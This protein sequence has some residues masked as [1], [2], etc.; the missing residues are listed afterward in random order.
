MYFTTLL[1]FFNL[2]H[3]ISSIKVA[4]NVSALR[5][6]ASSI[7][8]IA[9]LPSVAARCA[10]LLPHLRLSPTSP[11]PSLHYLATPSA[12]PSLLHSF[13][14]TS[15]D[16]PQPKPR[17]RRTQRRLPSRNCSQLQ[18]RRSRTPLNRTMR[19]LQL[20]RLPTAPVTSQ[21]RPPAVMPLG[22]S[23]CLGKVAVWIPTAASAYP[24]PNLPS[25]LETFSS[26]LPRTTFLASWVAS[27]R[28]STCACCA[29]RAG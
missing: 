23:A 10:S 12:R 22:C 17:S 4:Q 14:S 3:S 16:G 5:M 26:T 21:V 18:L 29:I 27:V 20:P 24:C 25:T 8:I 11:G 28:S 15:E 19:K 9:G 7:L 13:C 6:P 1:Y 2:Y